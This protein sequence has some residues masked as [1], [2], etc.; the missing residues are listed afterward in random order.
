MN[1]RQWGICPYDKLPEVFP[2]LQRISLTETSYV[3]NNNAIMVYGQGIVNVDMTVNGK[4][5]SNHLSEVWY[6]P[7][8]SRNL[9]SVS[10]TLAKGFVFRAEG[11]ECSF[12]RDGHIR[13]KGNRIVNGL[14]A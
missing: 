2:G 4:W 5:V 6:A 7:D 8:A 9:F 3:G 1:S 14:Y 10:Q 13:L 11:N 12:T